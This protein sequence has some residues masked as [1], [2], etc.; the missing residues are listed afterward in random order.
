MKIDKISFERVEEVKY[1]G[2]KLNES[3]F[4]SGR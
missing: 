3:K 4:Y 1:M 2:K